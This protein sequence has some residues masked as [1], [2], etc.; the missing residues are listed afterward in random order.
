MCTGSINFNI[1]LK[2]GCPTKRISLSLPMS[3]FIWEKKI[4]TFGETSGE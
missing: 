4:T 2:I 1:C 3:L